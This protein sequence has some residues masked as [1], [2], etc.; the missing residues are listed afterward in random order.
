VQTASTLPVFLLGLPS[1]ALADILDRRRWF[2]A[3]Q[4][5]V[6]AV[7]VTACLVLLAGAMSAPLLLVLTFANGIGLAMRWPVFAAIV[8]EIVQRP[9]L[10][11]ALA[12]NAIAM[13]ISRIVGPVVAGA[14]IAALGSE[15]VYATNAVASVAAALAI[16]TWKREPKPRTLPGERFVGAMRVGLT[17]VRE[18]PRMH[19]VLLRVA[20]FFLHSGA[21][22]ALLPLVARGMKG[23][24]GSFTLLLASMGVG[25]IAAA[26]WLPRLR[27]SASRNGLVFGGSVIQALAMAGAA[28]APNLWVALPLMAISGAAWI[29]VANTLTLSAQFVLPNWVRARGMSI[30]QMALMGGAA[31][32]AALWG[33]V[34]QWTSVT[35]ALSAA[36]VSS[37]VCALATARFSVDVA[38][39]DELNRPAAFVPRTPAITPE[40]DAGPV[41]MSLAYRIAP[42]NLEAFRA[43]MRESRSARL[44]GGALSWG[45]YADLTAP[46]RYV[47][48]VVYESWV[49]HLR[50]FERMTAADTLLRE[51]RHAMN[52]DDEPPQ[53][54]RWVAEPLD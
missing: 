23:G 50:H 2:M 44:R 15:A 12:L 34:A 31:A 41:V 17:Y 37:I 20:L 40:L 8:P 54:S 7:G 14:L 43:L 10:P 47:E 27:A 26:L 38:A 49:D 36:A 45:L 24:A 35:T 4:I 51:R 30:Y 11:A 16:R 46:G 25:A 13:N 52:V 28:W 32:G 18:S 6:A 39:D 22:L 9:H 53:V 48:H 5:W 19:A 3:T 33:Q 29:T 42:E 1:G 21:L